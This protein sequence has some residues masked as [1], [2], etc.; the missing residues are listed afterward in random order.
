MIGG[1]SPTVG[2]CDRTRGNGPAHRLSQP[3][4]LSAPSP[5]RSAPPP[6]LLFACANRTTFPNPS[7][8][9]RLRDRPAHRVLCPTRKLPRQLYPPPRQRLRHKVESVHYI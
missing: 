2:N 9:P 8:L 5:L 3:A 7:R 6:N 1:P 4:C